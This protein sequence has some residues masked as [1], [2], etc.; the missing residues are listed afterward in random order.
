MQVESEGA[1]SLR[2]INCL[3]N[4]FLATSINEVVK[5]AV[6]FHFK[7]EFC[8]LLLRWNDVCKLQAN[9]FRSKSNFNRDE[10][11]TA[12]AKLKTKVTGRVPISIFQISLTTPTRKKY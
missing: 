2:K 6:N 8:V 5:V 1:I 11:F 9:E 12:L 10:S 4:N 7:Y 3:S